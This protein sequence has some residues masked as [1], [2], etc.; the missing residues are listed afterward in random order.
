[1][2]DYASNDSSCEEAGLCSYELKRLENNASAAASGT[3][4]TARSQPV[5]DITAPTAT[6]GSSGVMRIVCS[7]LIWIGKADREKVV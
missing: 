7:G 4:S 3:A 5:R 2:G 1:M 6:E